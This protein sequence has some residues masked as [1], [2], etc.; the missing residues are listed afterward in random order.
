[1]ACKNFQLGQNKLILHIEED[2]AGISN[3]ADI[4]NDVVKGASFKF[5]SMDSDNVAQYT[6]TFNVEQN[7][8]LRSDQATYTNSATTDG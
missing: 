7:C 4:V 3:Q 5:G 6:F 2:S 8:S 1:M